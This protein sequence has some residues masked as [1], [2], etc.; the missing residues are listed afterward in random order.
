MSA[1]ALLSVIASIAPSGPKGSP[2]EAASGFRELLATLSGEAEAVPE[3]G[4]LVAKPVPDEAVVE[5]EVVEGDAASPAAPGFLAAPATVPIPL[6]LPAATDPATG[7]DAAASDEETAKSD[8]QPLVLPPASPDESDEPDGGLGT[9]PVL[10]DKAASSKPPRPEVQPA[11]PDVRPVTVETSETSE[12]E[13][14]LAERAAVTALLEARVRTGEAPPPVMPLAPP[15]PLLSLAER[16]AR[17][18]DPMGAG[19]ED[20]RVTETVKPVTPTTLPPAP[21]DVSGAPPRLKDFAPLM[22]PRD[23]GGSGGGGEAD[24]STPDS[25]ASLESTMTQGQ[26][27]AGVRETGVSQLSRSTVEATAQIAAQILRR[28][29]GRSTRFEMALTPDELGRVD[30]KLDIDAEGRLNARLAFDNPAAATDLR[31]RADELRRQLEDAGFHLADDAFEFTERD[32][33]SSAFDRGQ[34]ARNGSS[35]AFAAATRIN[36]EIDVAQP[37]RWLALT[38]S[39]SG[40]DMKV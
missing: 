5:A 6:V 30:V 32:S 25:A 20:P 21:A 38:L 27:A 11:L 24:G 39:P 7:T 29:E 10:A 23:P 28:L 36:D 9:T 15:A 1:L 22:M 3:A 16:R 31:G 26:T 4:S 34:D 14:T 13:L 37:P 40:V 35:R 18:L 19:G 33:N 12:T 17:Y 8:G 2:G